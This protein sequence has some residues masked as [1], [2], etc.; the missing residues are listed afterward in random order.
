MSKYTKYMSLIFVAV[1]LNVPFAFAEE[2]TT[3]TQPR[4][5]DEI[6]TLRAGEKQG[7]EDMKKDFRNNLAQERDTLRSDATATRDQ[8]R[9]TLDL[10]KD[11]F[12]KEVELKREEIKTKIE[13]AK[14][15]LKI[16][17]AKIKDQKKRETVSNINDKIVEL[18]KKATDNLTKSVSQI[19]GVLTRIEDRTN[20]EA[21]KGID[22]T[23][24]K[25]AIAKAK[26][27]IED[28]KKAILVQT[29]KTYTINI[30]TET[31]LKSTMSV[32]KEKLNTD[33]KTLRDVVKKAHV[34]VKEAAVTLAQTPGVSDG[35]QK[36]GDKVEKIPDAT[37]T[38][39]ATTTTNN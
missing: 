36:E 34:A 39:D 35:D 20:K 31:A 25:E 7:L 30:T 37:T 12:K 5:R 38:S 16:K 3:A 28:A 15:T 29:A 19:E 24:T 26:I 9:N 10:K 32:V 6:K 21:A 11:E 22:V 18:N 13:L 2:T 33:I 4:P 17:L 1:A 23:K 14:E 27:S 8:I